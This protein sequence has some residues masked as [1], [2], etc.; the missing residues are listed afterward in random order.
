MDEET[1]VSREEMVHPRSQPVRGEIQGLK[2]PSDARAH[3]VA[4]IIPIQMGIWEFW[5]NNSRIY[6]KTG[7][8]GHT[9]ENREPHQGPCCF[10]H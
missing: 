9:S 7:S 2:S 6:V 4:S 5:E 10:V 8:E 1:K 3:S